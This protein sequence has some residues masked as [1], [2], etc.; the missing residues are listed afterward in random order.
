MMQS[1]FCSLF[2]SVSV[3][4]AFSQVI[5]LSVIFYYCQ[6]FA[7]VPQ[8]SIYTTM[9]ES[10]I[11]TLAEMGFA[12][13]QATAALAATGNDLSK[14]IAYLFGEVDEPKGMGTEN[15]PYM[16]DQAPEP[17]YPSVNVSNP[18]DL[19]EFLGQYGQIEASEMLQSQ[20]SLEFVERS[21]S[22]SSEHKEQGDL[23]IQATSET[24]APVDHGPNV[25]G[26][27]NLVPVILSAYKQ[28]K[29]WVPILTILAQYKPFAL[30]V[31]KLEPSTAFGGEL[32]Q[33][34][35]FFQN[36]RKSTQW[37][38]SA[39]A[40]LLQLPEADDMMGDEEVVVHVY[41][42]I[43]AQFKELRPVFELLVESVEEEISKEIT[44]LEIDSDTRRPTLY[45]TLN[46]LFWQKGF[47]KLGLIMYQSVAPIVTYQ[48]V[49]DDGGYGTPF[50]LQES[51]YPE[52]YS[53]KAV[54]E[55]RR[56]VAQME[57]AEEE[58]RAA[59]RRLMEVQLFEGK[60]MA[61]IL[62]Q[63][64]A[65]VGEISAAGAD[66]AALSGQI[67][68]LRVRELG[69]QADLRAKA[70]GEQLGLF[71]RVIQDVPDM[72]RY[73][74]LGVIVSEFKYYYKRHGAWV[75]MGGGEFVDFPY[76]Q[77]DVANISRRGSHL[78]TLVYAA[79]EDSSD[80]EESDEDSEDSDM[81]ESE[82][83]IEVSSDAQASGA[84][85]IQSSADALIELDSPKE[86]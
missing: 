83:A 20:Y 19:P 44:V 18:E 86:S 35:H 1:Q 55:V 54:D 25:K 17:Q 3:A 60:K 65:V 53:I 13:E 42:S 59:M 14:A 78:V 74:L 36:F 47:T 72:T 80:S 28:H 62:A 76:V 84:I 21:E 48:L 67:E 8:K 45:Q 64:A 29:Y 43:M 52:I 2:R 75:K 82:D 58:R 57:K 11:H 24:D 4:F 49:G 73:D 66:L 33:I 56:E 26:P 7:P 10:N 22:V 41:E 79:G 61:P 9:D 50:E 46:E 51:V 71:E 31:L 5:H 37:Y 34:V 68:E 85:E 39:D 23:D 30:E 27:G 16:V 38:I 77:E 69:V 70:L 15:L 63:A 40:L 81:D 12:R 32:Q 6:I